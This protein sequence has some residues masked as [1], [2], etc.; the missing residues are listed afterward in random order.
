MAN[1]EVVGLEVADAELGRMLDSLDYEPD[2]EEKA[3]FAAMRKKILKAIQ[4][5][6]LTIDEQGL[7]TIHLKFPV[8]SIISITFKRPTGAILMAGSGKDQIAALTPTIADL[9]GQPTAIIS[10]L[11]YLTDYKLAGS[12]TGIFLG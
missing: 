5:G 8:G 2:A 10:K 6:H 1:K 3:N 12:L 4:V 11:D 7:P 9:T